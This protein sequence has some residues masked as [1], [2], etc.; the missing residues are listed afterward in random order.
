MSQTIPN[1]RS[2]TLQ[3]HASVF[4]ALGDVTR[5]RLVVKLAQREPQSISQL[6]H[7]SK[8][9]RQAVTKHL[10]ALADVGIVESTYVI[11]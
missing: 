9:S 10:K 11:K 4:A 8:L 5:L 1:T 3:K 2:A 7:G 6:T